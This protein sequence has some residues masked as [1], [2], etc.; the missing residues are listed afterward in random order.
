M[1]GVQTCALPIL[2]N[3]IIKEFLQ[4]RRDPKMLALILIS[5]LIQLLFLG[6]AA[7]YDV[8][9]VHTAVYNMDKTEES[10]NFLER[11]TSSNYFSFD[12]YVDS[13][14]ELQNLI[15]DGKIILGIT[16]PKNFEKDIQRGIPAKVQAVFDGSD[17][18]TAAVSAGYVQN[19]IAR[20]SKSVSLSFARRRG[21]NTSKFVLPEAVT[22]V[23]YNP[24]MRTR[25]YMV[26]GIV[27]L[28]LMIVT[29]MLTSLAIVKEREIG[30]LEQLIVTPIKPMELMVG[31]LVPFAILGFVAT[32]IILTT[33]W[34][35]FAIPIKG[36]IVFIYFS[37][38]LFILSTLGLGMFVSTISKTQQQAMMIAIFVIMMPMI[39]LSGFVFPIENMPKIIQYFTYLI[40]L[41][42]FL[43]II[44]GAILKGTGFH[45]YYFQMSMLLLIGV[46]ILSLSSLGFK[47]KIG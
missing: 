10:R 33:M 44:R 42:Y 41:R 29:L 37:T 18:N 31:K 38:L 5:P 45:D 24:M 43:T 46:G 20:Y 2:K 16:I 40:P 8:N 21:I 25:N 12:Y 17:G 22:R 34:L 3:I 47:K 26:P 23:W 11:F 28:L 15:D 1:T 39:Y 30:T 4:I 14:D 35:I 6:F 7:N 9:I 19:V 32:T 36:S 27:G 13:Y